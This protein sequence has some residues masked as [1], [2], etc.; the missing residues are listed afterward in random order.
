MEAAA[1]LG[2]LFALSRT[3][4]VA[5]A[6]RR[7]PA[8]YVL[9]LA[10]FL[11]AAT[12]AHLGRT[13]NSSFPFVSWRMFPGG[14]AGRAPSYLILEGVGADGEPV[15]VSGEALFPALRHHR[16]RLMLRKWEERAAAS[17][18]DRIVHGRMLE[19]IR[20][21]HNR[22]HPEEPVVSVGV[23]RVTAARP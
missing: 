12:G 1:F 14:E 10:G 8:V 11:G 6:V 2:V 20:D 23:R 15:S 19:A 17:P 9:L 18:P 4:P 21:A 7:G 3:A 22:A 5:E 13:S 16:V